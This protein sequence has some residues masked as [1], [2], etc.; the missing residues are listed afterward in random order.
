MKIEYEDIDTGYTILIPTYNRVHYL[1]RILKYYDSFG[2]KIKIVVA[3]SSSNENKKIN[4]KI[5][6]SV[7]NLD[8]KYLDHYSS[9]ISPSHKFA[10]MVTYAEEKYSVFCA[11]D[12][13][14]VPNGIKQSV[15][16]L[17]KNPDFT[18]AHGHYITFWLKEDS[19]MG[20]KFLF[21]QIYP[22]KSITLSD[23]KERLVLQFIN[24][25]PTFYAVHRTDFL[26]MINQ[27][28]LNSDVGLIQFGELL[29]NMLTL[30]YGKMKRLDVFYAA[31]QAESRV[32]HWPSLLEYKEMGK[33]DREYIKFKNC[34]AVHL[35][36]NSKL[37][38]E[39]AKVLINNAMKQYLR[40]NRKKDYVEKINNILKKM[41]LPPKIDKN[42]RY[43][44]RKLAPAHD[45]SPLVTVDPP[46]EY[47][48]DFTR[49]RNHV[50]SYPNTQNP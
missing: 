23:A 6:S 33:F 11:D 25:C 42:F 15:L 16:F 14:V 47:L 38:E 45:Y 22:Y 3:D 5:I 8:V 20:Q 10:D 12:D 9:K 28:L 31:R 49:I 40:K 43:L 13:F 44:Y 2:E 32:E 39:K 35:S 19:K 50:V 37:T 7:S 17:E 34:L 21:R 41:H 48:E 27:E 46:I 26:K 1:Q 24:Y 29:P 4:K 18:A 30:I 36:K